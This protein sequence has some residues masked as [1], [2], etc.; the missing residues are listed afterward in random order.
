MH[1]PCFGD[2]RMDWRVVG[3]AI[4]VAERGRFKVLFVPRSVAIDCELGAGCSRD[5][6]FSFSFLSTSDCFGAS[7]P[8]EDLVG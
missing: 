1:S 4:P 8:E 5:I 2:L 6:A 3:F 7:K